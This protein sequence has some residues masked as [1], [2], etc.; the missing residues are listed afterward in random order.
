MTQDRPRIHLRQRAKVETRD[1][2]PELLAINLE[3]VCIIPF[4][5]PDLLRRTPRLQTA[6]SKIKKMD[7]QWDRQLECPFLI[8]KLD[9]KSSSMLSDCQLIGSI[10]GNSNWKQTPSSLYCN[11]ELYQHQLVQL[12]LEPNL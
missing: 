4:L 11:S 8:W 1:T 3:F 10:F 12:E 2:N 6:K 7:S 9:C 5:F